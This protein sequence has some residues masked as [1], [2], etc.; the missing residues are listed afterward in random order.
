MTR[1][2]MIVSPVVALPFGI[3]FLAVVFGFVKIYNI[4]T[5]GMS[6]TVAKGDS[7]LAT[8]SNGEATAFRR[9][10]PVVFTVDGIKFDGRTMKGTY[11][12]RIVALPGDTVTIDGGAVH[13]NGHR[14]EMDG[15]VSQAPFTTHLKTTS[16]PLV[17][18]ENHL[19]M[20]GDNYTNSLDSRHFGPVEASRVSHQPRYRIFPFGR[21]GKID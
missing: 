20:M 5:G 15:R 2:M 7:I 16:F 21:F 10:Q 14:V 11:I 3:L 6:P 1:L 8:R 18:P 12:Q 13:V 4:P 19:F 9:D 17:I